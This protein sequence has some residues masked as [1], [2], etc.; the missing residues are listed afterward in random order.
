MQE[1]FLH[2]KA[3][4]AEE[5]NNVYRSSTQ[6]KH[7]NQHPYDD[8]VN[9]GSHIVSF[10]PWGVY[11][12]VSLEWGLQDAWESPEFS[13]RSTRTVIDKLAPFELDTDE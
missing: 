7:Q 1:D 3:E 10:G 12:E 8:E 11:V 9:V 6:R 2:T 13:P 5:G 4:L